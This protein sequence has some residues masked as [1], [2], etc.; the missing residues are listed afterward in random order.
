MLN[1]LWI[2]AEYKRNEYEKRNE[3]Q[4]AALLSSNSIPVIQIA[5]MSDTES[6]REVRD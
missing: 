2:L 3:I 5:I 4:Q 6:V 1:Y